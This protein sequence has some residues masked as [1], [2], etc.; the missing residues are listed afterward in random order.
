MAA[1]LGLAPWVSAD[2]KPTVTATEHQVAMSDGVHLATDVYRPGDGKGS[3]PVILVRT[4][5]N[6][7]PLAGLGKM[8]CPRGYACVCQDLRGRFKSEGKPVVI[9]GN[10]GWGKHQDGRETLEWIA[11]QPW[12]DGKIGTWGGSALGIVQN[13]AAPVAPPQL[14]AQFVNVAFSD[15]YRQAAYEG[16]AFRK[17]LLESWLRSQNLIEGN[18]AT[19]V[20]HPRYDDFWKNLNPELHAGQVR[21]PAVFLGGW[22]DIFAQGTINSFTAVQHHG[23]EG[24]RGKCRLVMAPV[25]HGQ[26][27]DLVYPA[28]SHQYPACADVLQWFGYTLKGEKN[29]AS[30]EKAVHYYVMGDPTDPKAPGNVWRHVD[31]WPPPARV[32]PFYLHADGTLVREQPPTGTHSKTYSYDPKKPVP[33]FGGQELFSPIGPK[34]QR[35]IEDR[36]DV[37]IFS[38]DKL[39]EPI[40]VTGR[41]S[42]RLF[43]SS[44]CPDTD[45]TAKLTDV[46]PDG[47]SML[48]SDGILRARYRK[49]FERDAFLEPGQ[50]YELTVD[51]WSTSL[52]FNKG[53]HIRVAVSSSN[54]PRFE[55]NPNTG[56]PFRADHET[57]VAKN[58]LHLSAEHPSAILLPLP[59]G[60]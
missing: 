31:D 22:Y 19:F 34:D 4:P 44:D 29:A 5:Y 7:A 20:A 26:F 59:S 14:K 35:S 32:T 8:V 55:P 9:F 37:L 28:N 23:G 41:I 60:K 40:E 24:A 21:A 45:F 38:T 1:L 51:L 49:G 46:Y 39:A 36:P 18:L 3:Y 53:H 27:K 6:K 52:V 42:A 16:G 10:D 13:M 43:V 12:C 15:Y 57:R 11:R 25:G 17:N 33:T 2:D 30:R 48:V 50:V 56:K 54:A 58:T 47:R